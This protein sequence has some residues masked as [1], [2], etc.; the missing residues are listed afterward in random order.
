MA[1]EESACW[2]LFQYENI[3]FI[4]VFKTRYNHKE[5]ILHHPMV[6]GKTGL[7]TGSS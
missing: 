7:T 6:E 3:L 2:G 1:K 5:V 4:L